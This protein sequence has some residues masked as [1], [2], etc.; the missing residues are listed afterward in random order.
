MTRTIP[1]R[2]QSRQTAFMALALLAVMVVCASARSNDFSIIVLPDPQHYASKHTDVGLAQ[3]EWVRKNVEKENIKFVVTVGDN[4][5]N[6]RDDGQYRNSISFMNRLAG[7]VPYGVATGNH[8]LI[9]DKNGRISRKFLAYYGPAQFKKY[10]W[11][12]GAS[13]SG[14][15][16]YQTFSGG[17][18]KF[19]ALELDVSAMQEE[20]QWAKEVIAQHADLPVI[21]TTHEVLTLKGELAKGRAVRG[22]GRQSP[23]EIWE[24]LIA[25]TPQ[26]FL[27]LCGHIHGEACLVKQSAAAQPVH[28]VLQDYQEEQHGGNGWLRIYTFRPAQNRIDVRTYSPFLHEYKT[29]T[30]SQFSLPVNFRKLAAPAAGPEKPAKAA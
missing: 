16:S 7:V 1:F 3:T 6:G 12:G 28:L 30:S 2:K 26:I 5:D 24:R 20:V 29:E 23:R 17:G 18:Y 13:P 21:L 19:L 10:S 11:Y 22:Q 15:S 8:D 9:P 4:V 25:P 14:F 27:V